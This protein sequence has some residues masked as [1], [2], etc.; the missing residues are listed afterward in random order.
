MDKKMLGNKLLNQNDV[1]VNDVMDC[2]FNE[3]FDKKVDDEYKF[4]SRRD[5]DFII[6]YLS[7]SVYFDNPGIFN[8]FS[9]WL[10]SLLK[11]LGLNENV[12]KITYQCIVENL[13]NK[14]NNSEYE[15][16]KNIVENALQVALSADVYEDT[17][18]TENN[19]HKDYAN[20]IS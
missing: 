15:Y 1:I 12:T 9:I 14:F 2:I 6:D 13:K 11:N 19:P 7:E 8:E 18:I 16:L 10:N 17:Y 4:K 5:L 3:K 20:K